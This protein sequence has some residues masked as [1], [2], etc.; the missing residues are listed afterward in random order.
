MKTLY[1][2]CGM[3]AAGDMLTAALL[4]LL[5][6]RNAFLAELNNIGIPDVI[7][8]SE[9][10]TKCGIQGT[11]ITV[12]VNGEEET[13][14][15][16]DHGHN[17][18]H[19]HGHEHT[20]EHS[21]NHT[22]EHSNDAAHTHHHSGMHEIEHIVSNL[23][24]SEKVKKDILEVYSLIAE[25]ESNARGVPVTEIHF[26]E[27]GTMDAVTDITAVCMLIDRLSPEQILASPVHVGSGHVKCAHGILP[28]PA[29]A[30][31]YIL[32]DV[33]IYGSGIKSELCTPTGAALLKHFITKFGEMPVMRTAAISYGMGKKDFTATNCVRAIL[34]TSEDSGDTITELCCNLDDMTAEAIGFAEKLFF[35]A[36][37]LDVY[38]IPVQMKKSR[39]GILLSVMCHE[40]DKEL[41][42]RLIFKHTTTLG[43]R[44]NISRRYTLSR[45][46]VSVPTKY[47]NVSKKVSAGYGVTKEKYE[48]DDIAHIARENEMN[49]FDVSEQIKK[50]EN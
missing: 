47:G 1:L 16:H 29:P 42:L 37:A 32:R 23:R 19:E 45:S 46:I 11:H 28:V 15:M 35:E 41:I 22:H 38:T 49:L 26:H 5:P 21:H 25:A 8:T 10:S 9:V 20:H 12:K 27:V 30:T 43:V 6:D 33:P 2:D 50:Q 18:S 48:F 40:K 36:G 4:E 39:P 17:H 44:E 24:V 13:E 31:A 34:G 3:G 7:V 14:E